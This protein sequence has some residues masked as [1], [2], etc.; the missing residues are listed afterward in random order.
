MV[1]IKAVL[2]TLAPTSEA[3]VAYSEPLHERDHLKPA[4]MKVTWVY[5]LAGPGVPFRA[6]EG[7]REE[8]ARTVAQVDGMVTS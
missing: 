7:V 8:V 1:S 3:T 4:R 5:C 6:S 2:N